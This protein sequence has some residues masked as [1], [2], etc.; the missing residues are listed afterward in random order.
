MIINEDKLKNA[1]R[2]DLIQEHNRLR[3][4]LVQDNSAVKDKDDLVKSMTME[5]IRTLLK[6]LHGMTESQAISLE[7]P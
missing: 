5:F 7:N 2:E 1:S 4:S 3:E 6:E